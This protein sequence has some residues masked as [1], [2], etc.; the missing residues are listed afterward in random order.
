[1]RRYLLWFLV[2]L[3]IVSLA[4]PGCRRG[5]DET[6]PPPQGN[7]TDGTQEPAPEPEKVGLTLYFSD[8]QAMYLVPEERQ[9]ELPDGVTASEMAVRELIRGPE[10]PELA[11]TIPKEARLLSLE[12]EGGI[13]TVDFSREL[14]TEHWGGSTGESF[15]IYSVVNTL[16]EFEDIDAVQ[17]L[18]E[19]EAL[20]SLAGH[21]DLTEPVRRNESLIKSD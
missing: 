17:F 4:A 8:D 13:A 12:V 15:T 18:V 11:I 5:G 7:G 6:Q 19:G 2:A 1:V 3:V 20:D 21:M 9:V 16:T 14:Q 10:T